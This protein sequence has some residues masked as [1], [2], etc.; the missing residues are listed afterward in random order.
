MKISNVLAVLRN[1]II[2]NMYCRDQWDVALYCNVYSS[3]VFF[4]KCLYFCISL[5][6]P[7]VARINRH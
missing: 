6:P 7:I 5:S 3:F 4:I 1:I 2:I